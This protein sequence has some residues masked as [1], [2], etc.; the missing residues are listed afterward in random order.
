M[1]I[2]PGHSGRGSAL[3]LAAANHTKATAVYLPQL[4]SVQPERPCK[5]CCAL[6][7]H[8]ALHRSLHSGVDV[9]TSLACL[10]V[11]VS[12]AMLATLQICAGHCAF[13][14]QCLPPCRYALAI[15][16]RGEMDPPD[17]MEYSVSRGTPQLVH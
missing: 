14:K 2:A 6:C 9:H 16:Q 12:Q 5:W 11:C 8:C 7:V 1:A 3:C 10:S 15:V 17:I 13:C 4:S